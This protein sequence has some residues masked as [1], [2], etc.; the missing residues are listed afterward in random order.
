MHGKI[1]FSRLLKMTLLD[2]LAGILYWGLAIY[3]IYWLIEQIPETIP[4]AIV[5][6]VYVLGVTLGYMWLAKTCRRYF[7]RRS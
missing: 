3:G 6:G 5:L 2:E 4:L 7:H 1:I